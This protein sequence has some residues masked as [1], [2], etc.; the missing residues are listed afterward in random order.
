MEHAHTLPSTIDEVSY[1]WCLG[2]P[3]GYIQKKPPKE[4]T[5]KYGSVSYICQV[6]GKR[7]IKTFRISETR[8]EEATT[9]AAMEYGIR[10]S[11]E[12]VFTKNKVRR[13]PD[14]IHWK[15]DVNNVPVTNNTLEVFIDD[16][17][18]MLIDFEDLHH[19]QQHFVSKTKKRYAAFSFKGTLEERKQGKIMSK[20]VHNYLTGYNMVDHINR[21]RMDNRR[22][23]IRNTTYKQ[24]NN[25]RTCKNAVAG[26][27]FR[28]DC[29]QGAWLAQIKQDAR[30]YS[31]YFSMKKYGAEAYEMAVNKR[32][33]FCESFG[34]LNSGARELVTNPIQT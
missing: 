6:G 29:D 7:H 3:A 23:N 11:D 8:D 34:C 13:L 21:N 32:K 12:H 5:S 2:K 19:V 26:V 16:E 22:V 9:R 15:N 27:Y 18:T 1:D 30:Q 33:E 31:K 20:L 10:W 25:N 14:G 4:G 24:N 28:N 17:H